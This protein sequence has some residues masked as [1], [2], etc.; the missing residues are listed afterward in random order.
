MAKTFTKVRKWAQ[1]NGYEVKDVRG[2]GGLPKIE[3]TSPEFLFELEMRESTIYYS[4]RG[5]MKGNRAGMYLSSVP[6]DGKFHR[7]YSFH[8]DSQK[9]AINDM[10]SEI[11][12]KRKSSDL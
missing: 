2:Y 10:K 7:N 12:M 5:G 9:D 3:I 4:V 8:K 1:D 11:E 6:N